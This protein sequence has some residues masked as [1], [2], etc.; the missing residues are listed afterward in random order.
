MRE[1]ARE[2]RKEAHVTVRRADKTAAFVL[3]DTEEYHSKLDLILGDSYKFEK[4][5]YN[6]IEE[7]KREANKTIEKNNAATNAIHFQTI[8]GDFSPSYLYGDVKTHKNGN[9]LRP[10]ISQ[11]LTPT[12]HLAKRLNSLLIASSTEFL[13][14]QKG[15]PTSGT[16][17]S[18]DVESLFTNVP[19]EETI[20]L[21]LE[22]VYR[23]PST[24]T[25]NIPEEALRTLHQVCTKKAPFTA[26]RGHTYIQKD[27]VAM[28][29]S[30]GMLFANFYLGVV[31]ER[32]FSRIR[33]PD[34][35]V[36][37]RDDTF[38]MAPSAQD[39]E[40]LRRTFEEC[41][42]L[43]FTVEHSKDGLL[44]FLDVL[45]SPNTTSFDTSVYIK[46]TNRGL[47]LNGD[48]EW[49][50]RYKA[51]TIKAYIHRALFLCS[52]WAAT[53]QELNRV[54]Q[55]LVNYGY[56]NRQVS[57]EIELA[58]DTWYQGEQSSREKPTLNTTHEIFLLPS[59]RR[60]N[61]RKN[62]STNHDTS[63]QDNP[64]D[65]DI[66]N[67]NSIDQRQNSLASQHTLS[68]SAPTNQSP[69]PRGQH[70][71]SIPR[72]EWDGSLTVLQPLSGSGLTNEDQPFHLLHPRR[73]R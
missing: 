68:A 23:D 62:N 33:R 30:L 24:P 36:R 56:S 4:P 5:S 72:S 6:P 31:E 67:P 63:N 26:H 20:D 47:S 55:V 48:S 13:G 19:V 43:R 71:D 15:S 38:I 57:R 65:Q 69:A 66:D 29:S 58:M 27:G 21:I 9:P 52:S 11:W 60:N 16:I 10:I 35:Y 45:I 34:V 18:L 54:A 46:P 61:T 42:C 14:K 49:P 2:L 25:L 59:C 39:I 8:T 32:V 41:S 7:I 3:I 12:Y 53:H 51:C 37:Y 64:T 50:N 28:V 40:T 44:P 22:R 17:A 70:E 73:P 1:A